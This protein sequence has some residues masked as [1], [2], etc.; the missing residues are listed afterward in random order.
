LEAAKKRQLQSQC[1]V[2][3]ERVEGGVIEQEAKAVW[4]LGIELLE[5]AA[6]RL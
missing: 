5:V 3:R 2:N 1:V 6:A 4:L